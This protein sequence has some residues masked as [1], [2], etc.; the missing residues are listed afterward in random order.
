M[1]PSTIM[2]LSPLGVAARAKR[3]ALAWFPGASRDP[4]LRE[5]IVAA[6]NAVTEPPSPQTAIDT[7]SR[8]DI[9]S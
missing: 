3:R 5:A 6:V 9:E 7:R 2:A 4:V 1:D 8:L